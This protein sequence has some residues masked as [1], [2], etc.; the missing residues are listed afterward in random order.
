[1]SA[2]AEYRAGMLT[3]AEYN[4]ACRAEAFWSDYYDEHPEEDEDYEERE[5]Y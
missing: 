1:M 3:E 4:S 2:S 5:E